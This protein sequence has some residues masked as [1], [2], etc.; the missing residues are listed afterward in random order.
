MMHDAWL[1]EKK[2]GIHVLQ[3][4]TESTLVQASC[5]QHSSQRN[6]SSMSGDGSIWP[7]TAVDE[8]IPEEDDVTMYEVL[9][10]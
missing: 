8:D 9:V 6:A 2:V 7:S 10:G 1:V 3:A 5:P 4:D